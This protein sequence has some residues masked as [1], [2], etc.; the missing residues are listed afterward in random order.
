MKK[1]IIAPGEKIFMF[2]RKHLCQRS[3]LYRFYSKNKSHNDEPLTNL[4]GWNALVERQVKIAQQKGVFDNL[5]GHG[6]PLPVQ[7]MAPPGVD[8]LEFQLSKILASQ[9]QVPA[10]VQLK[11]DIQELEK[12]MATC[13]EV[14]YTAK[15]NK[16]S[17]MILEFN[18]TAPNGIPRIPEFKKTRV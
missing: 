14:D 16:I 1:N 11:R 7:P 12:E 15:A 4:T 6:K 18:V 3:R 17:R 10:W 2:S 8:N 9:G 5:S 13:N